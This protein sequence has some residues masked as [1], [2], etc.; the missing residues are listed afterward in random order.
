M[1]WSNYFVLNYFRQQAASYCIFTLM[2]SFPLPLSAF[3]LFLFSPFPL[4]F[5][6]SPFPLLSFPSFLVMYGSAVCLVHCDIYSQIYMFVCM[7]AFTNLI[8]CHSVKYSN[9]MPQKLCVCLC[10]C[11]RVYV[12]VCVLGISKLFME[13]L[14]WQIECM[15]SYAFLMH[16]GI[17]AFRQKLIRRLFIAGKNNFKHHLQTF[18]PS[19]KW[20]HKLD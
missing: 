10:V 5:L 1:V 3:L 13:I 2:T 9:E 12:C 6:S 8:L 14:G 19:S 4:L 15:I 7:Q 16:C 11:L 18:F 20:H 17:F